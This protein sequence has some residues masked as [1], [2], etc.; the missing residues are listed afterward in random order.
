MR[1]E[2]LRSAV[3][4]S[5]NAPPRDKSRRMNFFDELNLPPLE[6]SKAPADP[7]FSTAQF[8]SPYS[9]FLNTGIAR[10]CWDTE[11]V[12][13]YYLTTLPENDF[14]GKSVL[15]LGCGSAGLA[16]LALAFTH[17]PSRVVLTDG[18]PKCISR[19]CETISLNSLHCPVEAKKLLWDSDHLHETFDYIIVSDCLYE[20]E[21][22]GA[23]LSTL[24]EHLSESGR[25]FLMNPVRGNSFSRFHDL[26]A[27]CSDFAVDVHEKY[28]DT[29]W[30][31]HKRL[32]TE[33]SRTYDSNK[34]Y[35]VLSVLRRK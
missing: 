8:T 30:A 1:W 27:S 9:G 14:A 12:L 10:E 18:N 6:L 5:A 11:R 3:V 7:V 17:R 2:L 22:H 4:S 34:N 33:S 19:L 13:A 29:V 21:Y 20:H 16:G 15:E 26:V 25:I 35:P 28:D 23:L 24:Q 32:Q 31:I